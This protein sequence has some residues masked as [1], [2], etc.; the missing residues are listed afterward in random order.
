LYARAKPAAAGSTGGPAFAM[1]ITVPNQGEI[2]RR[3]IL[4]S[5]LSLP[6]VGLPVLTGCD[7][8]V[9]HTKTVDQKGDSTVV[10]EK[11]VTENSDGSVTKTETKDV[12]K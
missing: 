1:I 10:K 5:M 8:E 6:M 3:L 9:E 11:K 12:S 7:R 4:V 2:M